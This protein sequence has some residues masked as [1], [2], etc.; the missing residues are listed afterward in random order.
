MEWLDRFVQVMDILSSERYSGGIGITVLS[1]ECDISKSTLHRM[2]QNMISH[3][4]VLQQAETKKYQL[5]PRAMVWGSNFIKGQ[6]VAKFLG[7][8]CTEL[9]E[10]T[11]LY[12][13]LCRFSAD[14]LYC[15]VTRQPLL[16][17]HTYFVG[18][19]QMMPWH[20]SAC[21]KAVLA[22]QPLVFIDE[23]L[24]GKKEIYTKNTIIDSERLKK[25]LIE[26]REKNIAW[27]REEMEINVSAMAV[28]VFSQGN[29]VE[30]SFS[31]VGNNEYIMK[32]QI[33]LKKILLDISK[34]ASDDIS[35]AN[36]L[37]TMI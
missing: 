7:K 16:E 22:F 11:K 33:E 29:K 17:G 36:T 20:C 8:Y 6:N 13:F 37:T 15:I 14:K 1:R 31:I 25:E 10:K 34:R 32:N 5:G 19:G 18:I 28:P 35:I 30:Y 27:C 21:A 24:K 26:I 2:L 3:D 4:L 9:A 23:I 12:S